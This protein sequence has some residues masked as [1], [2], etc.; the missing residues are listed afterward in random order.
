[1]LTEAERVDVR[2]RIAA[3]ARVSVGNV[4]KVQ[5][6]TPT[7][8]PELLSALRDGQIS[9]NL[10]WLLSKKSPAEQSVKLALERCKKNIKKDMRTLA[11]RHSAKNSPVII[12]SR[13]LIGKLMARET[14]SPGSIAVVVSNVPGRAV[15]VT[16]E[17]LL[18][19][20][21]QQELYPDVKEPV[22]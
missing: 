9:V 4:S 20:D 8:I 19:V 13:T 7:A 11:G 21:A 3:R 1:M 5:Q 18:E 17:L 2:S 14:N 16:R 12:D 10:G 6:L 15:A 22:T